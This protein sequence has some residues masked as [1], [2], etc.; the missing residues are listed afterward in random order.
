MFSVR[1][2]SWHGLGVVLDDY[3]KSI[4][5]ALDK[6]GLGWK[7]THGELRVCGQQSE[8]GFTLPALTDNLVIR[9][10]RRRDRG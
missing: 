4:D 3:P 6:A 10:S 9:S 1:E 8:D 2:V 5:K 7:V